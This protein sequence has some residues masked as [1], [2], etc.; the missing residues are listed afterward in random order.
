MNRPMFT[1]PMVLCQGSCHLFRDNG[2][3][4]IESL[5]NMEGRRDKLSDH[6]LRKCCLI[7]LLVLY[8]YKMNRTVYRTLARFLSPFFFVFFLS[9]SMALTSIP[10]LCVCGMTA[11]GAISLLSLFISFIVWLV[12]TLAFRPLTHA[13]QMFVMP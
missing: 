10:S 1:L 4:T 3:F 9:F 12:S 2:T 11:T 8:Q 13:L 6:S 5:L 7:R